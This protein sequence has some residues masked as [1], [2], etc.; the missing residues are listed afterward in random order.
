MSESSYRARRTAG[1]VVRAIDL[2]REPLCDVQMEGDVDWQDRIRATIEEQ[3]DLMVELRRH[4]HAHPEPS[5][6]ELATSLHLYQRFRDLDLVVRMGPE[7]RGVVVENEVDVPC[8]RIALRADI[9]ALRIQDVKQTSYRSQRDGV[10]HA[11]GHDAH[12]AMVFGALVGLDRLE[13]AAELPWPVAWRGIFQPSE[14]TAT[15]AREMV[16]SGAV[17][18]VSGVLALHVD[19]TRATGTIGI[20]PGVITATCDAMQLTIRGRGGHA[21]RPHESNDPIAAAAQLISM[22]YQFVPRATDSLDSVVI[23]IGEVHG[24]E[25]PNVIPEVVQLRGTLRTLD[26]HVRRAAIDQVRQLA[27]G[28]AEITGTTIDVA[29]TVSIPSVKND[30]RLTSIIHDVSARLLGNQHCQLMSRASMGSEDFACYLAHVPGAM[31]RLGAARDPRSAP[32]LHTPNFDI[33][34]EA[35]RFGAVIL[36]TAAIHSAAPE[37]AR[38]GDD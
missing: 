38:H 4:L 15:G 24:G 29:F 35:M 20:K 11:C 12:T 23:S 2:R 7:G 6:D 30:A 17:D 19:P 34:E 8:P 13:K 10:L 1:N 31:F 18:N 26:A 33:D 25:N 14:E 27:N 5:G 16:D 21:A 37:G 9:D 22:L 32:A 28:L 36:A 3:F